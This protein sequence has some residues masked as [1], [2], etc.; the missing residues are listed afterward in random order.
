MASLMRRIRAIA[1]LA[2]V[3]FH[4]LLLEK[5]DAVLARERPAQRRRPFRRSRARRRVTRTISS[6]SLPVA[7]QVRD[8]D[9]RRRRGRRAEISSVVALADRRARCAAPFTRIAQRGTA[10]SSPSLCGRRRASAGEIARRAFQIRCAF[11]GVRPRPAPRRHRCASQS[12]R[13]VA[14]SASTTAS[15]LPSTAKSSS[16]ALS[17]G[18]PA[19]VAASTQRSVS[20]SISSIETG[21]R[22]LTA[23]ALIARAASSRSAED[24]HRRAR[25]APVCAASRSVI[26]VIVPSVPSA[27]VK[28]ARK[29]YP[30]TFFTESSRRF[31]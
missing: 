10:M 4:E 2:E 26:S 12:R 15:S 5:A 17:S 9:C 23:T 28:S 18:R 29:L 1:S 20:S 16:A 3:E 30:V 14:S 11:L 19:C 24:R 13:C 25:Q 21:G 22:P 8:A 31:G 7:Q 6:G 27:P